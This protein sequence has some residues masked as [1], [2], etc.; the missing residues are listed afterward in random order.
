M[1][2]CVKCQILTKHTINVFNIVICEKKSDKG[3]QPSI[4]HAAS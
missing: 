3:I 4:L 1:L 2:D